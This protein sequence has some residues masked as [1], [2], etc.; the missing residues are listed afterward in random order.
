MRCDKCGIPLGISRGN[1]WH[2]DGSISGKYPPYMKGTFFDVDEINHLLNALSAHLQYD[3]SDIAAGGKYRDAIQYMASFMVN[4]R[5][6]SGGKL[7]PRESLY[8]IMMNASRTWGVA[9]PSA[10]RIEPGKIVLRVRYPYSVPLFGGDVAATSAVIEDMDMEARWEGSED[11]GILTVVPSDKY[12]GILERVEEELP[13]DIQPEMED[14]ARERC[15]GCGAPR[16]VSE[17]FSWDTGRFGIYERLT[18]RRYCFNNTNGIVAALKHLIEELGEEIRQKMVEVVREHSRELYSSL[19]GDFTL[20]RE[21]KGF[22]FKGWGVV[23]EASFMD[24]KVAIT[25]DNPY[26]EILLNGRIWGMLEAY[27]QSTLKAEEVL[28]EAGSLHLSLGS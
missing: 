16:A 27:K 10:D 6:A 9:D 17:I 4:I 20:E 5:K 18:D 11:E 26:S 7:P 14:L 21:L 3:I 13:A 22:P 15:E 23:G 12:S 19:R 1:V 24:E 8:E 25:V 28:L 2:A